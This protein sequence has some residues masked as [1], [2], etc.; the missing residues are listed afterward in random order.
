M[1]LCFKSIILSVHWKSYILQLYVYI[2]T[3]AVHT[4]SAAWPLCYIYIS[5]FFSPYMNENQWYKI[6]QCYI[7]EL[8]IEA[9]YKCGKSHF[10]VYIAVCSDEPTNDVYYLFG[11]V[12]RF[13]VKMWGAKRLL[14]CQ[15]FFLLF[16]QYEKNG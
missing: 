15:Y 4:I 2:N 11:I 10:R 9:E 14:F 16:L 3:I 6:S 1:T 8:S 13:V 12:Y 7:I 5:F